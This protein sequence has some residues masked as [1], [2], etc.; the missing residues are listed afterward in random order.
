MA[1]QRY[2]E[3]RVGRPDHVPGHVV[4]TDRLD[5]ALH[6]PARARP[7]HT[8]G[9]Q[10]LFRLAPKGPIRGAHQNDIAFPNLD[11]SAGLRSFQLLRRNLMLRLETVRARNI[12]KDAPAH[13]RSEERRVG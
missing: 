13:D 6:E 10:V 5:L 11:P 8:R 3:L 2:T 12:E 9:P 7:A 4:C 1:R